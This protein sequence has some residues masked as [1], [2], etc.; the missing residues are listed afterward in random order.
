MRA[1]TITLTTTLNPNPGLY[2]IRTMG[3]P[4]NCPPH[5]ADRTAARSSANCGLNPGWRLPPA[6]FFIPSTGLDH[7][8]VI[9][10]LDAFNTMRDPQRII[11][12]RLVRNCAGQADIPV[13]GINM[14]FEPLDIAVS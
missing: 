6:S 1:A 5:A 4:A 7:Q 13:L 11:D 3:D 10:V 9:D 2:Q 12:L 8:R 14:N